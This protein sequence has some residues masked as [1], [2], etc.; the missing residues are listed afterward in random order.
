MTHCTTRELVRGSRAAA[1]CRRHHRAGG[2]HNGLHGT[3]TG[4]GASTGSSMG[5]SSTHAIGLSVVFFPFLLLL[6]MVVCPAETRLTAPLSG[7]TAYGD[8]ELP[9]P[10]PSPHTPGPRGNMHTGLVCARWGERGPESAAQQRAINAA[11][12]HAAAAGPGCR[13]GGGVP[14]PTRPTSHTP[15]KKSCTVIMV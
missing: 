5:R 13:G 14:C 7:L 11:A 10:P 3:G 12:A 6:P 9:P 4:T 8:M 1:P 2:T 15:C